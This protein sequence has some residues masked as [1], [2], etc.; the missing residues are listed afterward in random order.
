MFSPVST[1]SC[2]EFFSLS[3]RYG[4]Q[5]EG[6]TCNCNVVALRAHGVE[7]CEVNDR[8]CV[9]KV[10]IRVGSWKKITGRLSLITSAQSTKYKALTQ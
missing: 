7:R 8:N 5:D 2:A 4:L 3:K 1:H 9:C 6:H 10:Q